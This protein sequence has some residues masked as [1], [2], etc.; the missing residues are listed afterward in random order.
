[1]ESIVPAMILIGAGALFIL[2]SALKAR[3]LL[4]LLRTNKIKFNVWK[5]LLFLMIFFFVGYLASML[6]IL[7]GL[8]EYLILLTAIVFCL[9]G[10]FVYIVTRVS[11]NTIYD[12][13]KKGECEDLNLELKNSLKQL[14]EY[15]HF[16]YNSHDFSCIANMKGYFEILNPRWTVALGFTEKELLEKPVTEFIHPDDIGLTIKETEK[17]KAGNISTNFVNR[18]CKKDGSYLWFDWISTA[19]PSTGKIFAVGRDITSRINMEKELEKSEVKFRKMVEEIYDGVYTCDAKGYFTYVNLGCT[20]ITGYSEKELIGKHFLELI[21]P[22]FKKSAM[23]FYQNQFVKRISETL[24]SFPIIS[25][26][27]EKKWVEQT[28]SLL[29]EKNWVTG[30]QCIVRD[31]TKRKKAE[32]ALEE[33][34]ANLKRSNE[35]LE[36]FAYVTT[37]DLQEPLRTIANFVELFEKKYAG[38]IDNEADE[39]LKFILTATETMQT[40]IKDLLDF[41]RIG[42][43]VHFGPVDSNNVLDSVL[44]EMQLTIRENNAKITHS[45]LP[46]LKAN[47]TELKRLF[48]NLISNAIKFRK[49]DVTPEISI[50]C[51]EK[52][53]MYEFAFSDNGIGID[54][55]YYD[56][57]F[58]IFQRLHNVTE[59]PG[60]GIGLAT[61]KKIIEMHGGKI[62]VKSKPGSGS[63]FYFTIPK[64]A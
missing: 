63:T 18:Y 48:Q 34:T 51:E 53:G 56:R 20:K 44:N 15:K 13:V 11:S 23:D 62:W 12:L 33:K 40:L 1:M 46:V 57:I 47:E 59:Y 19:D 36:Q 6:F 38:Q 16:F 7:A 14:E 29:T 21:M 52:E 8:K 60:T 22:E 10:L 9:G 32:L 43:N 30:F 55:Q 42:K 50:R 35:E 17:L 4:I 24:Y 39:Y 58:I 27:G 3:G 25:K 45:T 2:L 41:S 37:H 31:I 54:E 61:C 28:V 26:A 64:V 49:K 5:I